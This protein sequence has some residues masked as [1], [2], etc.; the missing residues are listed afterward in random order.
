MTCMVVD[1]VATMADGV[2][3]DG[4]DCVCSQLFGVVDLVGCAVCLWFS[5]CI[6][7]ISHVTFSATFV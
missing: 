4:R 3:D 6:P 5:S 2:R 7:S 1:G